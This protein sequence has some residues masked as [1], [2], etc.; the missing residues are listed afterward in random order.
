M[1]KNPLL[2]SFF[3]IVILITLLDLLN[4]DKKFSELENRGLKQRVKFTIESFFEGKFTP[5]YEEYIN[6][7][8]VFRDNWIDLKARSEFLLG[9]VENNGIV[10]GDD[11]Y[12]FD[13]FTD[14][15][16]HRIKVNVDSINSYAK[17]IGFKPYVMLIPNSYNI[18]PERLPKN[19]PV[20][21]QIEE[22]DTIYN[23]LNNTNNI[24]ITEILNNEKENYIYY[25]T[26]HH[27]TTY[28]A[29]L[30]YCEYIKSIGDKPVDINNLNK[31]SV[32]NFYGTYYS[33][34]KPF[35]NSGDKLDYY[36]FDNIKMKI[37]EDEY[38]SLYD[39]KKLEERDKYSVFIRG[40]NPLTI[41]NNNELHN[42]KKLLIFKD[43]FANSMIPFLTQN[44]EEIHVI[45]LRSFF[46][47]VEEYTKINDFNEVLILYNFMNFNNDSNIVKLK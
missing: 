10:Y 46:G 22:I 45:D 25:K 33:K 43:S 39:I 13:K 1:K 18:Y 30:A 26:D 20:I 16:E 2:Y 35:K 34:A 23:T 12:L 4:S 6:D 17:N 28:G 8:F 36:E 40:N 14:I 21:N 42:G 44:F 24:N 31:I 37:E 27:W 9:K 41:I 19:T 5:K 7:Q 11:E 15:D 3:V 47:D 32:D 29:Y 38:D